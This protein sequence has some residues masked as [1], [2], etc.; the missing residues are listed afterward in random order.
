MSNRV[1]HYDSK[2]EFDQDRDVMNSA[3]WR[4]LHQ[5][6]NFTI[7]Y[8]DQ[9]GTRPPVTRMTRNAFQD[10]QAKNEGIELT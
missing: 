7:T 1:K 10:M 9:S 6:L 8:S 5:D 3:G 4:V 2:L